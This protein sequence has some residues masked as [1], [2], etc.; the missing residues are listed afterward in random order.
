MGA[1]AS[2]DRAALGVDAAMMLYADI[3]RRIEP[4]PNSGCWLWTGCASP[5]GYGIVMERP[6]RVLIHRRMWEIANGVSIPS[7]LLVC[8]RCDTP[9]C[10]NPDHLFLGTHGDNVRDMYRKGRQ[11]RLNILK[12][13]AVAAE[14][15]RNRTHCK[16]GHEFKPGTTRW[17]E[18]N[19]GGVRVCLS[20]RNY[21]ARQRYARRMA[22]A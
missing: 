21:L 22:N 15:Y 14:R 10:I 3:L 17:E 8:H 12:A 16:N 1:E 19:G 4:E 20:C 2:P 11:P 13:Q 6:K 7:G 18:R 9:A 5:K